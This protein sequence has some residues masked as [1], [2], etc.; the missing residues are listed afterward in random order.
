MPASGDTGKLLIGLDSSTQ[1]TKALVCDAQGNIVAEGRAAIPLAAPRPGSAEQDVE[2]WWR[3]AIDAL[4]QVARQ[5]DVARVAGLAVSNQRE[6][7][8]F[9]D[10]AG[11]AT[12]PALVWLDERG[13]SE[14]PIAVD[15]LGRDWLHD[16]TGKPPDL[17]PV[18]YRLAW[19]RRHKPE[20]LD[21]SAWILDVQGFLVW[22]LTG[23][24]ATSWTSADPFAIFDIREKRW[25]APLLDY[26]GISERMLAPTHR[27]GT[28]LGEITAE[29]AAAT[30]LVPGTPVFAA[31]GD[32]QCA[33]LGVDAVRPGRV[34]LN[35][36]T[37][38]ITGLWTRDCAID[39]N[40]RTM[41]SPTGEG[42]FLE[43]CQRAG[44]F[45][46]N[47]FADT[48]AGGRDDATFARLEAAAAKL[49][50]G[51]E[52][53]LLCPYLTGCMDPHWDPDARA[54]FVGLSPHHGIGHLYRAMLEA[55]TLESARAIDAMVAAGIA[56]DEIVA[57]G[58]GAKSALWRQIYADATGLP[59]RTGRT[60]DA[61]A[62][63][64]AMT[65][66]VGAGIHE[67]FA[68]AAKAMSSL[69]P[70]IL[71]DPRMKEQYAALAALQGEVYRA[72][73]A[74]FAR[75]K[76]LREGAPPSQVASPPQPA[77]AAVT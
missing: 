49:P 7:S 21:R 37:A 70:P 3:A 65:A 55:I 41:T 1:S 30:G 67:S 32:G 47:W 46:V 40:W 72:N 2:D 43:S 58:G 75:L 15:A 50:V 62:V 38:I 17:T 5:I 69:E 20:V 53:L 23:A 45:L 4:G 44:A 59:V 33:G 9:L 61:S 74:L 31:G 25:S 66:A 12:H 18:F 48:L 60:I 13:G 64:A 77:Q 26:L 54:A 34:Y 57:I 52:G 14:I 11:R 10:A 36:G 76:P 24:P 16:T 63:G 42:Y 27:P 51:A 8:A 68:A 6:T 71:P 28:K 22:R 35:L 56:A 29:A 19:M 73:A 39:H